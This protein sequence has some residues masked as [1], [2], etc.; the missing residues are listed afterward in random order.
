MKM[1][2][3]DAGRK[4]SHRDANRGVRNGAQEGVEVSRLVKQR[5]SVIAAVEN[6]LHKT[7]GRNACMSG[8]AGVQS[9]RMPPPPDRAQAKT[10]TVP[11]CL[12]TK[13]GL[14]PFSGSLIPDR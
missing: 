6:M 11:V 1:V 14:S 7:V 2:P 10:G 13:P 8:H 9:I 4:N 3:R 12:G 5:L